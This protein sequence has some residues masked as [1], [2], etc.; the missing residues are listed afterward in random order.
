[1][2]ILNYTT[3][4]A[5]EKSVAEIQKRLVRIGAEAILSEYNPQHILHAL[6]FRYVHKGQPIMFRMPARIESIYDV[7]SRDREVPK[8][9]K[10]HE[11]ASRVAWRIVK[12][13]I[14]AQA[15]IVEA[16]Q[17]EV[18]EVFL[19]YAQNS[20]TGETL[21]QALEQNGFQLLTHQP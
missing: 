3:Q 15:A 16:E 11:Q 13:W 5:P 10:T 9:L 4:I 1:M 20:A 2:P 12:D 19:P 17:A 6:S 7:L 21:Y 8:R 18:V 14:E